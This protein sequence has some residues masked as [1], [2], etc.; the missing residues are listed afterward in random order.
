MI[1]LRKKITNRYLLSFLYYIPYTVLAVMTVPAVF[2]AT[3]SPISALFGV[4]VWY[5]FHVVG[6]FIRRAV[7]A[8]L[9]AAPSRRR[10]ALDI[11]LG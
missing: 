5:Y 4:L 9:S 7:F 1:F 2:Y 11:L 6:L 10:S 8:R 3:S